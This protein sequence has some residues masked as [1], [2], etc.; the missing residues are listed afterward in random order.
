MTVNEAEQRR[1]WAASSRSFAF[2]IHTYGQLYDATT[3][4]WGAMHLWP[5]QVE[6]G[7]TLQQNRL[8]IMLKARQLGMSWLALGYALWLMLFRPAATVL[9]FSKRDDEAVH[10]LNF[11]LRGMYQRLPEWMQSRGVVVDN[12]HELRLTNG[13]LALA[14]PTTGGRSYTATLAVVDEADHCDNL[15]E[16]L[17]AVKPTVDAGGSLVLLSTVDKSRPESPFKRIYKAAKAGENS[18]VPVFLPWSA[19]PERS[20]EWYDD[21]R[22]DVL[23][24]SG[25]LDSLYAE[26]PATDFEALAPRSSDRRFAAEWLHR[27]DGTAAAVVDGGARSS[28]HGARSSGHG[29]RS[30][31]HG[32]AVAG[33]VAWAAPRPGASYVIG[34]DPAEGNPQSDESAASVID[35]ATCEQVA[36]LAG[37]MDPSVFGAAL[38][39]VAGWYNGAG[40]LVERNNHGHAVLLWLREFGSQA[41]V[42]LGLD[43]RPGWLQSGKG[44]ALIMD[45]AADVLRDAAADAGSDAGALAPA[46]APALVHDRAT[47]DQLAGIEGATLKAPEGQHDDRAVAHCLALAAL[48]FCSPGGGETAYIPGVDPVEVADRMPF[49]ERW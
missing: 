5:A 19:R 31:G 43:D 29:A 8:V 6:V 47:L 9:L 22:R 33:L 28:G 44:K 34:A 36:V 10:L 18:Y 1:E 49:G 23:A 17:D 20:L 2:W 45:N 30:S 26:Y 25:S 12:S 38:D 7:D 39:T 27:C 15:E 37:R 24:R 16:L 32:P 46:L 11:R 3:R 40:V 13:S 41:R 48:R 4:G 14:F 42:L 35:A 21:V